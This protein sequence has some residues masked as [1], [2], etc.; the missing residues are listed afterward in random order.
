MG[1]KFVSPYGITGE[2]TFIMENAPDPPSLPPRHTPMVKIGERYICE[3]CEVEIPNEQFEWEWEFWFSHP[4]CTPNTACTR[5][6]E[7]HR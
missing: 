2:V 5:Q 3:R 1:K 4:R 6:R 7:S